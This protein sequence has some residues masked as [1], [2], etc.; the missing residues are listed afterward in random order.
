MRAHEPPTHTF[1]PFSSSFLVGA[2]LP[3][4]APPLARPAQSVAAADCPV[5]H[6][7]YE[8]PKQGRRMVREALV[9][10]PDNLGT[11][12]LIIIT[13]SLLKISSYLR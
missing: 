11:I 7:L 2:R 3:L 9:L 13:G 12:A 4:H 8:L 10:R 6:V 1:F 5:V